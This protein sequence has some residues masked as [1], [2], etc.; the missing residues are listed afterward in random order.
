MFFRVFDSLISKI[1]YFIAMMGREYTNISSRGDVPHSLATVA[2]DELI[3]SQEGFPNVLSSN[4][5]PV[6]MDYFLI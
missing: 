3:S 1:S 5:K 4:G 6:Q 2:R